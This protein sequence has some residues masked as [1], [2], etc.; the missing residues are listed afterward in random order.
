MLQKPNQERTVHQ[1]LQIDTR[2][3]LPAEQDLASPDKAQKSK[4]RCQN[5]K[6]KIRM[7]N[8]E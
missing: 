8:G 6:V 1:V 7:G 3:K 5:E 2:K 4:I